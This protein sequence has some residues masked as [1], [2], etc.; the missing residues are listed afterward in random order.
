MV[1]VVVALAVA[2]MV[3]VAREQNSEQAAGCVPQ[4]QHEEGPATG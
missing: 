4:E 3:L 2:V 1:V